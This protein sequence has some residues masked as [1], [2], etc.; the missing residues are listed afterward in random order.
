MLVDDESNVLEA[1]SR[2]L[3]NEPYVL[4]TATSAREALALFAKEVIDIVVSDYEMRGINGLDFLIEVREAYRHTVRFMLTGKATLELAHAAVSTEA[5]E[6]FF[7][8]PCNG[9]ELALAIRQAL[10]LKH[11]K[12]MSHESHNSSR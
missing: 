11:Q 10:E 3:A 9:A 12:G 8:K 6:R 5:I 4:L 2:T 7:P 1:L